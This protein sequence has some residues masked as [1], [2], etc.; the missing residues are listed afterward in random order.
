M[1][2]RWELRAGKR[3]T[4]TGG[5]LSA[6]VKYVHTNLVARD[7]KAL[8]GFY[9]TVFE[10]TPKPPERELSGEWLDRLT[11][12]RAAHARGI[13][14]LLPGWGEHGPTLEIFQ[15]SRKSARRAS[16]VSVPGF[17]HIAFSVASPGTMLRKLER[18]GGSR[19]GELIRAEIAGMGRIEVV[20]A[21]D[22]EGNV[23]ELQRWGRTRR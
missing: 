3:R 14:L 2:K 19:V 15:Y 13:H 20:Y 23:I 4:R 7:W 22:P 21:R 6:K 10:C 9:Q 18:N 16:G 5:R 12:M 17:G 11:S 8:A 1:E